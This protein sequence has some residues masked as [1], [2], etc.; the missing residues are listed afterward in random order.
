MDRERLVAEVKSRND[1]V[2]VI[3]QYVH[4]RRQGRD[5][6]GLCPF[7]PE[8]TPSFHVS[9]EKQL[10]YCFGC[11]AG[12]DVIRFVQL[13]ENLSF[14]EALAQLAQR[15]GL[16]VEA[17]KGASGRQKI[18]D[19]LAA[20]QAF[21]RR[22]LEGPQGEEA[23]RY[24]ASRKV[25]PEMAERFGLGYAPTGWD[26]L[27]R[28]LRSQGFRQE[29][30][31]EAG[32]LAMTRRGKAI[33]RFR[34]RLMFPI[35]DEK[36]RVVGFGGRLLGG[37]GPKY[38]NSPD[39]PVFRKK[40]I[41]YGW[42]L[43]RQAILDA[44]QALVVEGYMD[45]LMAHAHGFTHAVA[46]LGTSLTDEQ[47][48][49]LAR[50]TDQAVLA[51]DADQAGQGAGERGWEKLQAAGV[52]VRLLLL[53]EGQDPDDALRKE[54][55]EAF[56]RRLAEAV[57]LEEFAFH[58][59]RRDV[60]LR[61][62]EGKRQA[63]MRLAPLLARERDLVRRDYYMQRYAQWLGLSDDAFRRILQEYRAESLEH[64]GNISRNTK[65]S[66][67]VERPLST[68]E[69][70]K[71]KAE[72]LILSLLV[73]GKVAGEDVWHQM[74]PEDFRPGPHRELAEVLHGGEDPFEHSWRLSEEAQELLGR[75]AF[76]EDAAESTIG[77]MVK[78]CVQTMQEYRQWQRV[79]EIQ[80]ALRDLEGQGKEAP[81]ELQMELSQLLSALK[82]SAQPAGREARP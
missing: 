55:R 63:V 51:Y 12:G 27:L 43:A 11:H 50:L 13:K 65:K 22:M 24:L 18:Y 37:E 79:E 44:G 48:Q 28:H 5:Y 45:C 49:K 29:L 69:R 17:E 23:R 4:L 7:H 2:E 71:Q 62:L 3:G 75:L 77:E 58:Q 41:W 30:L 9:P 38:L 20:A 52:A 25:S 81:R 78:E 74:K 67:G 66:L 39:S 47:A 8:K 76:L 64:K 68:R 21:Y 14:A 26:G 31:Q 42:P 46:S 80:L 1:I 56:A 57:P 54:G 34:H 15:V 73:Q 32:L 35:W 33:D 6:V 10:F 53:P 60:D 36:G 16:S 70:R 59:I 82:R 61:T 19:A 40:E 72:E